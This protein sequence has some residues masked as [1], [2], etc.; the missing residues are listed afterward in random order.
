M[1]KKSNRGEAILSS[2]QM[3]VNATVLFHYH[4]HDACVM[5]T[6]QEFA[7]ITWSAHISIAYADVQISLSHYAT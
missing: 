2:F 5:L 4:L 6:H 7:W 3:A 1:E